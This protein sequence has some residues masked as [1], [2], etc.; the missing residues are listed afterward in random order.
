MRRQ[1]APLNAYT[2]LTDTCDKTGRRASAAL[3]FQYYFCKSVCCV[4]FCCIIAHAA[5]VLHLK[6][7]QHQRNIL[8]CASVTS[9]KG[10]AHSVCHLC[11]PERVSPEHTGIAERVTHFQRINMLSRV[12][13]T[14]EPAYELSVITDRYISCIDVYAYARGLYFHYRR[15]HLHASIQQ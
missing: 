11:K 2:G 9:D 5:A 15:K 4:I 7:L 1:A 6:L 8:T 13:D 3:P 10:R 14:A 12:F